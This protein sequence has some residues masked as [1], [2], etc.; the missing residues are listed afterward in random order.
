VNV[1]QQQL[2]FLNALKQRVWLQEKANNPQELIDQLPKLTAR[3]YS[4]ASCQEQKSIDLLVRKVIKD[5]NSNGLCSG[6][7]SE[8]TA[9]QAVKIA[10]K[11]HQSFHPPASETPLIMIAAG[12]G[13]A[14]FIGFLEQRQRANNSG[15]S[16]LIMGER[17]A[18]ND[19]YFSDRL[20]E[21]QQSGCLHKRQHAWSQ[22]D[23]TLH[24]K[25]VGDIIATQ[26]DELRHWLLELNGQLYICGN[27]A[28][29]G[30]SCD[31]AL[32]DIFGNETLANLIKHKKIKYDLY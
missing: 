12:T 21:F 28:T 11:S 15:K 6:Y 3:T 14:P 2:P 16:W 24:K 19:S 27:I 8:L 26:Q 32:T 22:G 7:L 13:L 18:D 25:Y 20:N 4:I 5:D 29:L 10:I 1:E 17:D 9:N 23:L 30:A 31:A